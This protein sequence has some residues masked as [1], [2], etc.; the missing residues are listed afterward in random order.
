[1]ANDSNLLPLREQRC[2]LIGR[3]L[4]NRETSVVMWTLTAAIICAVLVAAVTAVDRSMQRRVNAFG[5]AAAAAA[6]AE[7]KQGAPYDQ[8]CS[9]TVQAHL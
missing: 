6:G 7:R 2:I 5:A 8:P 4:A 1:M 9:R 3:G